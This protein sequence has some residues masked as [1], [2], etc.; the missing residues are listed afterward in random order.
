MKPV[1]F[2]Q[3]T[4]PFPTEGANQYTTTMLF[5]IVCPHKDVVISVN[6]THKKV[7]QILPQPGHFADLWESREATDRF[8]SGTPSQRRGVSVEIVAASQFIG[9]MIRCT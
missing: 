3:V 7:M 1:L 9:G 8:F 2:G 4:S 5:R 6:T